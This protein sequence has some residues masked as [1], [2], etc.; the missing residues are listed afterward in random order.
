MAKFDVP[1]P[2]RAKSK[3]PE[4]ITSWF[5]VFIYEAVEANELLKA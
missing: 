5:S 2:P 3:V 1:P 4:I